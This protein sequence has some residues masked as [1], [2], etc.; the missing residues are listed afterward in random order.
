[1]PPQACCAGE[2]ERLPRRTALKEISV[3]LRPLG[4]VREPSSTRCRSLGG[5]WVP[6]AT[7]L[8]LRQH[9]ARPHVPGA[10]LG[11]PAHSVL[12]RRRERAPVKDSGTRVSSGEFSCSEVHGA[13]KLL[14]LL[15]RGRGE[16]RLPW[17]PGGRGAGDA[18]LNKPKVCGSPSSVGVAV[19]EG[20]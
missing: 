19:A 7:S 12:V 1:M 3:T 18:P 6:A 13:S 5:R 10:V 8:R 16:Q 20:E 15:Q 9:R 11:L 4:A 17:Q 2:E 14:W